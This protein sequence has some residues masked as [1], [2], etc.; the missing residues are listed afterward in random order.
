MH[1]NFLI[2]KVN[3]LR[4]RAAKACQL[5]NEGPD[6]WS[7]STVDPMNLLRAFDA[8]KIK[9][10]LTLRA[11]QYRSGGNGNGFVWAV[12][13]GSP[14][15]DP[16][17]VP[18]LAGHFLEPPKPLDSLDDLMD[19]IEGDG[20]PWS[21]LS[22]SIFAREAA[23]FGALWHG[24]SWSTHEILGKNPIKRASTAKPLGRNKEEADDSSGW[25]W[26]EPEPET[27][28]PAFSENGDCLLVAFFTY[29]GA[30]QEAIS[31]F[32]DTYSRGS[33]KFS[34]EVKVIATGQ[35]GYIF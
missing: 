17:V 34:T 5:P 3:A 15:L 16:S 30:G 32:V 18:I 19:A 2:S 29:T 21:Y 35:V 24:C 23:E 27:W 14:F 25:N 1:K 11:Y 9:P 13:E 20:T 33:Y 28:K 12:P 8:L 7:R 4:K 10:G 31:G 22:A 6:G 26:L